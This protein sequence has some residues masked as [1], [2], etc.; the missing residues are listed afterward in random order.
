MVTMPDIT[1]DPD[2]QPMS[3][4]LFDALVKAHP[5]I[6]ASSDPAIHQTDADLT[7]PVGEHIIPRREIPEERFGPLHVRLLEVERRLGTI[8]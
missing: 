7:G 6:E 2:K 1:I 8:S 4:M 3:Q 5:T